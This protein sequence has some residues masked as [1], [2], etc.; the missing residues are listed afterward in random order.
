MSM[1]PCPG[2][3]LPRVA[4]QID[5]VPCPVCAVSPTPAAP[6]PVAK[7][8]PTAPDPTAGLPSDVS[9]LQKTPAAKAG[10]SSFFAWAAVFALGVGTGVGSLLGWQAAFPPTPRDE[11]PDTARN[12][13]PSP[14]LPPVKQFALAPMPHEPRRLPEPQQPQPPTQ[15]VV[16]PPQ[17]QPEPKPAPKPEQLVGA[18]VFELNQPDAVHTLPL[19]RKGERVVLKGK[20]KTLRIAGLDAGAILDASKLEADTIHISGKIDGRSVLRLYAPA[21]VV[22]FAAGVAGKSTVEI[23]APGGTVTFSTPTTPGRPGA[24]IDAGSVVTIIGRVVDLR[25]EVNGVDTKVTVNL[26]RA[27]SLKVAA[28]RGIAT[29]EYRV[30][31]GDGMPEVTVGNVSPTATFKKID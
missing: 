22:T 26:P 14:S 20:V 28:V 3:G 18:D 13:P 31:V 15:P 30:A 19:M 27:G 17:P 29:V 10:G 24:S 5:T 2:C 8:K 23:S 4:D 9:E 25:G 12:E 1:I 6:S 21:G 16:E 11:H 7:K